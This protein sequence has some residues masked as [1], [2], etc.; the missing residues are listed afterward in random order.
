[1][2]VTRNVPGRP[3]YP[4]N[5]RKVAPSSTV[6]EKKVVRFLTPVPGQ[7]KEAAGSS[8]AIKTPICPE[9][10]RCHADSKRA[11]EAKVPPPV[12][13]TNVVQPGDEPLNWGDLGKLLSFAVD[14]AAL[15][16]FQLEDTASDLPYQPR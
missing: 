2:P 3:N 14:P 7:D 10:K 4:L 5:W 15:Q 6:T 13:F 16:G 12:V 9:N 11:S 8:S 1:M